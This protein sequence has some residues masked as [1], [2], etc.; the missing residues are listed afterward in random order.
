MNKDPFSDF[1]VAN[2]LYLAGESRLAFEKF[3]QLAKQGSDVAAT[4]LGVMCERGIPGVP[5]DPSRALQYYRQAVSGG[6]GYGHVGIARLHFLGKGVDRD[7]KTAFHHYSLAENKGKIDSPSVVTL[8]RM[9]QFGW[10]VPIDLA[11]AE[12]YY[13]LAARAGN[14]YGRR[15]LGLLLISS[16]NKL[17]GYG[18]VVY[19]SSQA[20]ILWL[21][22]VRDSRVRLI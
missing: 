21:L 20:I 22:K 1:D 17:L 7:L 3:V 15:F 14:I 8:G 19:A 16:G 5:A 10:G 4:Y 2:K 6:N 12:E 13:R 18:H 9:H 11:Q